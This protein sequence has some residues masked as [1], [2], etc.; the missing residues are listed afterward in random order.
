MVD[1]YGASNDM[2]VAA[3]LLLATC[4]CF[5]SIRYL[6]WR[7]NSR[8]FSTKEYYTPGTHVAVEGLRLF[9]SLCFIILLISSLLSFRINTYLSLNDFWSQS[10]LNRSYWCI[11]RMGASFIV[12]LSAYLFDANPLCRLLCSSFMACLS[13]VDYASEVDFANQVYCM[14][15][16]ICAYDATN[17]YLFHLFIF[18]DFVSAVLTLSGAGISCWLTGLFGPCSNDIYL[19]HRE[20]RYLS[21]R[22]DKLNLGPKRILRQND[23][24]S[25]QDSNI[26]KLFG[27]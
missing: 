25:T 23:D 4:L 14:D 19:P 10:A 15:Q 6:Y 26:A 1:L 21:R 12:S 11:I 20:H 2:F 5:F 13:L 27:F 17:H 18:R 9:K 8:H 3:S 22:L 24:E 7:G 16:G